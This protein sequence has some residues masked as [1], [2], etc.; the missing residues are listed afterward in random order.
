MTRPSSLS[1]RFLRWLVIF[2]VLVLAGFGS[3]L[4]AV[5]RSSTIDE[6]DVELR[7]AAEVISLRL[8]RKLIPWP[9][10][11]RPLRQSAGPARVEPDG[12]QR[13]EMP[14][15][16]ARHAS[17]WF[18]VWGPDGELHASGGEVPEQ[19]AWD[20]V[21]RWSPRTTPM[22]EVAQRMLTVPGNHRTSIQ[23][24]RSVAR[25]LDDL[26][27]LAWRIGGVGVGVLAVGIASGWWLTRRMLRPLDVI[28]EAAESISVEQL[29][30]RIDTSEMDD[31]LARLGR[32]LNTT[33]ARLESS[34]DQQTRFT[35]DASHELRTPLSVLLTRCE[36]ALSR[37]RESG[38]YRDALESIHGAGKRMKAL[39]DE[40]LQLARLDAGALEL[41]LAEC[42]LDDV[43]AEA[44]TLVS[45]AAEKVG[46]TLAP[47]LQVV[48]AHIDEQR[49]HQ[50]VVNLVRNA[51]QHTPRG[52][53][54]DVTLR[55]AGIDAVLTVTD[56]G[57]GIPPEHLS[58]IFA[59][60]HRVDA[61]RQRARGGGTG[62]GLAITQGI[63]EAHGGTVSVESE[64]GQGTTFR[65]T[66]P[67][68]ADGRHAQSPSSSPPKAIRPRADGSK[69][70]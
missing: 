25:E 70:T 53:R 45:A 12:S 19:L 5:T 6:V 32:V 3:T 26:H 27:W 7:S 16:L 11:R 61:S 9:T 62:I 10:G 37:D 21:R 51:I 46:V 36:L 47:D 67:R 50:V 48:L 49:M 18:V 40:L 44:L 33:F 41:T 63:V 42:R 24:G 43:V 4:Y 66:L 8:K 34:F 29:D 60:F 2:L 65:V 39:V 64:V 38:E 14:K 58:A 35:A 30:A 1:W 22:A 13:I 52:G 31:E 23:V 15:S 20:G 57:A 59:R 68:N 28:A 17:A 54:I 56:T 69:R 55:T